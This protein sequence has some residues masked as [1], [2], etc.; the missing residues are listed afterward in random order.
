MINMIK[1][2]S[3]MKVTI[4]SVHAILKCNLVHTNNLAL[5]ETSIKNVKSA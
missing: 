5:L 1:G 2:T 4:Y 3:I